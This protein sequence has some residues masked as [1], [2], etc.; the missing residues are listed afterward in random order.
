MRGPADLHPDSIS[1]NL[2]LTRCRLAGARMG[3]LQVAHRAAAEGLG[4]L[5]ILP[6]ASAHGTDVSIHMNRQQ[7]CKY[8][9]LESSI[10]ILTW[11]IQKLLQPERS[12]RS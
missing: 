2:R 3:K 12:M 4:S 1:R 8:K 9:P 5:F 7:L 10:C 6:L 11:A